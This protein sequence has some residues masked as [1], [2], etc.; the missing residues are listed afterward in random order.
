M[1]ESYG[2]TSFSWDGL[3]GSASQLGSD[4][5]EGIT[6]LVSVPKTFRGTVL[7]VDVHVRR[8]EDVAVKTFKRTKS[9]KRIMAE[10]TLQQKC[11][12]VGVSP[13]VYGVNL[14]EKYI[15]MQAL[16][17]LPA[18]TWAGKALPDDLQYMICAL[19]ARMDAAEVLHNDS[20]ALNVM[21]DGSGRPYL[22]D[23]GLAKKTNRKIIRKYGAHPNV[24]VTLWG[25]VR[26]FRR[27]KVSVPIMDTC[28]SAED[29]SEYIQ[30]G[31]EYLQSMNTKPRKKKRKR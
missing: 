10:A 23:L 1:S 13:Y 22:I 24:A 17:S 15:V 9:T 29:S 7:D 11:A 28:V 18:K 5:K 25:L 26:G 20:N 3:R 14:E 30:Q 27:C 16:D 6:Y 31:E 2:I 8:N 21:L 12:A 4:G 19:M